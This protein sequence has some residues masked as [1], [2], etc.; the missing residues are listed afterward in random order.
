MRRMR[1]LLAIAGLSFVFA[2]L[3][4]SPVQAKK[5]KTSK[6]TMIKGTVRQYSTN[7]K[8]KKKSVI[9]IDQNGLATAHRTGKAKI[10][11]FRNG[12]KRIL[13]TVKNPE[14]YRLSKRSG[15]YR[16]LA[17]T[18]LKVKK[19]YKAYYSTTECFSSKQCIKGKR[20]K[21]FSFHNRSALRVICVKKGRSLSTRKLN[22]IA[23]K[24]KADFYIFN[25]VTAEEERGVANWFRAL[26]SVG[27]ET[28]RLGFVYSNY[29][30]KLTWNEAIMNPGRKRTNCATYIS[31]ALQNFAPA[32]NAGY[33]GRFYFNG[34]Q[35]GIKFVGQ[36]ALG[37]NLILYPMA[38]QTGEELGYGL[39]EGDIC[40]VSIGPDKVGHVG[41]Y[42]GKT[43]YGRD[44]WYNGGK[45][46]TEK[47]VFAPGKYKEVD[48][49]YLMYN[50]IWYIIRFNSYY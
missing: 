29:Y 8:S 45:D 30:N 16:Y 46:A 47:G 26:D 19:G 50:P 36:S 48:C 43:L 42:G 44:I 24:N 2:G 18:K 6:R 10:V 35:D 9:S 28:A 31:Y 38:G 17:K 49:D 4:V 37:S 33:M 7:F 20:S 1:Y 40:L 5:V 15:N 13:V 11:K 14:G 27:D 32:V 21:K 3:S 41:V 39:K 34:N 23:K 25:V 22:S 12:K